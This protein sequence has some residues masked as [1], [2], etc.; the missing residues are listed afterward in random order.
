MSSQLPIES[1]NDQEDKIKKR[2]R[3]IEILLIL[4]GF[5]FSG[6]SS[7]L[8]IDEINEY[9]RMLFAVSICILIIASAI[10]Y[11]SPILIKS[12]TISTNYLV[13]LSFTLMTFLFFS[14]IGI[15]DIDIL[16]TSN[17][18][19]FGII[20]WLIFI[21]IW[22]TLLVLVST[23]LFIS[24]DDIFEC[25]M[26]QILENSNSLWSNDIF[27]SI[28]V[29]YLAS[30]FY[31]FIIIFHPVIHVINLVLCFVVLLLLMLYTIMGKYNTETG[32]STV[33]KYIVFNCLVGVFFILFTCN[34]GEFPN[35]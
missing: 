30:I 17:L 25:S 31:L 29:P 34:V 7:I 23:L 13:S 4:T 15:I 22:F 3:L 20:H 12:I 21:F 27:Y 19:V 26:K 2:D 24:L 18:N 5:I 33:K 28:T 14:F 10:M 9:Q 6:T 32:K 16:S 1:I 11:I 35:L 8:V